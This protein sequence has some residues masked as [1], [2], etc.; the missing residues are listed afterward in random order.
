MFPSCERQNLGV[1]VLRVLALKY[2]KL[3][4]KLII[5]VEV[6]SFLFFFGNVACQVHR[7]EIL[8][9]AF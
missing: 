7:C 6:H 9:I 5:N 4:K 1:N 2:L 3:F 8:N